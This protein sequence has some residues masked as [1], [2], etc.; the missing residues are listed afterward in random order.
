MP[1]IGA[2][3]PVLFLTTANRM[4]AAGLAASSSSRPHTTVTAS[5]GV[6]RIELGRR[7]EV[8]A[9]VGHRRDGV[10]HG[11]VTGESVAQTQRRGR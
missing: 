7:R 2:R 3:R 1:A 9:V 11:E 5:H 8:V 4:G 10:A 6:R